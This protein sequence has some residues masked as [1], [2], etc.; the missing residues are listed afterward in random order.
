MPGC[1]AIVAR[2]SCS[3]LSLA[4]VSGLAV[5][6]TPALAQDS[7][8]AAPDRTQE[9]TLRDFIHFVRIARYDAAEALGRELLDSGLSPMEFVDLVERTGELDRFER[10]VAEAMRVQ[11]VEEVAAGLDRLF[12]D[13]K[14]ARARHPDEIQRNIDLLTGGLRARTLARERLVAAGEYAMPQLLESFL[15]GDDPALQAQVQRVMVDLGRQSILP[16]A[17]ALEAVDPARQE[18]IANVLA[19]IEYRTSLPYLTAVHQSTRSDGVRQATARAIGRLQGDPNA[20]VAELFALLSESFY[21]E[22]VEL[23]SFLGEPYQLLWDYDPG[24][25]LNMTAIR[26]EV[27]HEAMAMRTAERSLRMDPTDRGVMALWIA[28]NFSREIDSPEG[29]TN[30]VYGPDRRSA[31]YF[32]IGA[33][34]ETTNRV[35]ARALADRDTP[36]ALRSIASVQKTAGPRTLWGEGAGGPML[37]ALRYPNR[38]VQY[39]AALALGLAQP[40][41]TFSG[42]Q[43]V[44][45][46][47]AGAVKDASARY[48][49]VLTGRDREGYDRLRSVLVADGYEV[50]PP[51]EG[52]L[53][54]IQAAIAERPGIDLIVM[55]LPLETSIDTI[56]RI[57]SDEAL[58]VSP[59]LTMLTPAEIEPM[60]RRFVRDQSVA[61]RRSGVSDSQISETVSALVLRASGGPITDDEAARFAD[62]SLAVLRDLAVAE[63]TVLDVRDASAPLIEVLESRSGRVALDVAEVLAHVDENRAQV[64]I[65]ERALD[66]TDLDQKV[67]LLEKVADSGKRYGNLLEDR[68]VRRLL[69]LAQD[70]DERLSTQAVATVG[71]LGL[72]N[73]SMLPMILGGGD[74]IGAR[75]GER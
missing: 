63:N 49:I 35:V 50:L 54:D 72:P 39:E 57:R 41:V 21:N 73:D 10:S 58:A 3:V 2:V 17:T 70:E 11:S 66:E 75:I 71:A 55:S 43:R 53:G 42:S 36:L 16:L 46:L 62:R 69:R 30:P 31:E 9:E 32:A 74:Q 22:R 6:A 1:R 61:I 12:R 64:A 8:T 28:A 48:A 25:G 33:G 56:G 13:G 45:P 65:M 44:V 4:A 59:V 23:T 52:G 19:L 14:L 7:A 60:R 5:P 27:F 20:S 51:A 37:E 18:A 34:A 68:L 38:R 67:A 47:L 29:Y 15:Q 24:L 40:R 26:T